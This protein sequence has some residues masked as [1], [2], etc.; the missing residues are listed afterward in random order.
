MGGE[1]FISLKENDEVFYLTNEAWEDEVKDNIIGLSDEDRFNENH[2]NFNIAQ[3][4][5]IP[6][7]ADI[8]FR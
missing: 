7:K 6:R 4:G 5:T 2:S 1:I 8:G 3:W